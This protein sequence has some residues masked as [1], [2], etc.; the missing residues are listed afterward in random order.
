MGERLTVTLEEDNFDEVLEIH[1]QTGKS[2]SKIVNE[3]MRDGGQASPTL[4]DGFLPVFGQA[5]FI[6]GFVIAFYTTMTTGLGVSVV[7]GAVII[8]AKM[9]DMK[10]RHDAGWLQAFRLAVGI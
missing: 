5:L 7:G 2:K 8:G 4:E 6:V 1:N 9:D 10:A 3:Q